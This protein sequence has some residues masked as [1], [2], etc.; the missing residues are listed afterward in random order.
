MWLDMEGNELNALHG[1][2]DILPTVKLIYTEVNLQ[3]FWHGCVMYDEL[4]AWLEEHGFIEI[5]KDVQPSWHGNALFMNA[6]N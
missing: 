5:W 3:Q 4:K 6:K 2:L 1:A